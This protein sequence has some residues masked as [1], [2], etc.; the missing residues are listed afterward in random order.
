MKKINLEISKDIN[1]RVKLKYYI[2]LNSN[3]KIRFPSKRKAEDFIRKLNSNL[4]DTLRSLFTINAKAYEL[5]HQ[6]YFELHEST[7][8]KLKNF[9]ESFMFKTEYVFKIYS[10]GNSSFSIN[11]FKHLFSTIEEVLV[12]LK[13]WGQKNNQY[14]LVNMC[15]GLFKMLDALQNSFYKDLENENIIDK[16]KSK[17]IKIKFKNNIRLQN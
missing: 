3:A 15:N 14:N 12:I 5:F 13:A 11:S 17:V 9:F 7:C 10:K 2:F 4:H 6:Y 16:Y 8:F 1:P